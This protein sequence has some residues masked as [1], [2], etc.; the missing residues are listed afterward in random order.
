MVR[1]GFTLIELMIVI[2]IVAIL[3]AVAVPLMMNRV[4]S[5]KWSEARAA[6]GSIATNLK[7]W[8]A[9]H[10]CNGT[11]SNPSLTSTGTDGI[12]LSTN[13]LRGTYF[14][15]GDYQLATGSACSNGLVTAVITCDGTKT[16]SPS[17]QLTLTLSSAG[18]LFTGP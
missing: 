17:G 14:N 2:L 11:S 4:E 13:D 1:K 8:Y 6:M 15:S 5:A 3:A 12:G 9:E 10:G 16:D 7:A 18:Q